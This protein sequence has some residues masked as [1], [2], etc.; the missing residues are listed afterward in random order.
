MSHHLY[1][2]AEGGGDKEREKKMHKHTPHLKGEGQRLDPV[3]AAQ[4]LEL[5]L[6]CHSLCLRI[7]PNAC[8]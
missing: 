5:N 4:H 1:H 7:N 3:A 6:L 8:K 2:A